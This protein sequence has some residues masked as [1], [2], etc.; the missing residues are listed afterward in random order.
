MVGKNEIDGFDGIWVVF[1]GYFMGFFDEFWFGIVLM[2][3]MVFLWYCE[4]N[5]VVGGKIVE[6]VMYFDI[7]YLMM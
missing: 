4:F 6:I 1:M 7:L 2:G 5:K 3:K